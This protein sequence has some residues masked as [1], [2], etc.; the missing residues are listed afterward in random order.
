MAVAAPIGPIGML[1]I[2]NSLKYGF[3]GSI[4]VA[5]DFLQ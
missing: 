3:R 2:Q 5:L 1:F 4:A